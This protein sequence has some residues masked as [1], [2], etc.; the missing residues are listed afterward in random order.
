MTYLYVQII[1]RKELYRILS[2]GCYPDTERTVRQYVVKVAFKRKFVKYAR[3]VQ[4]RDKR[5]SVVHGALNT[6]RAESTRSSF[7]INA[8]AQNSFIHNVVNADE[9]SSISSQEKKRDE[10]M[11]QENKMEKMTNKIIGRLDQAISA[12]N[13]RLDRMEKR[14]QE[15]ESN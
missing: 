15:K 6:A 3:M 2:T 12:L 8:G 7:I 14:M 9:T 1:S 13:Q 5:D 10:E 11:A 4:A